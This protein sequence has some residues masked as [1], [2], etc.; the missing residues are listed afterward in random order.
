MPAPSWLVELRK[1]LGF[2]FLVL[3]L[4]LLAIGVAAGLSDWSWGPFVLLAMLVAGPLAG[5][6]GVLLW[7]PHSRA[8][9]R[10]TAV[11]LVVAAAAFVALWWMLQPALAAAATGCGAGAAYFFSKRRRP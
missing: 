10:T 6:L 4:V 5:G 9:R 1:L 8:A 11:C 7:W 3:G 2:A